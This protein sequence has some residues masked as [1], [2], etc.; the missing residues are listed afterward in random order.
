M[1]LYQDPTAPGRIRPNLMAELLGQP[2]WEQHHQLE[3]QASI[4]LAWL[5]DRSPVIA[6][7]LIDLWLEDPDLPAGSAIGARDQVSFPSKRRPDISIDVGDRALQLLIEVKVG[8]QLAD[9]SGVPQDQAY[10]DEWQEMTVGE[11]EVRAVGT[12]T[13]DPEAYDLPNKVSLPDFRARDVSWSE[14]KS[15]L[16][17][18]VNGDEVDSALAVVVRSFCD[19]IDLHID[20]ATV[21]EESLP[22][23]LDT[24]RPLVQD[25]ASD[26]GARLGTAPSIA[27]GAQ[28]AGAKLAY[29]ALDGKPVV[30]RIVAGVAG[31]VMTPVGAG[32]TLLVGVGRDHSVLLKGDDRSCGLEAG[33]EVIKTL[34]FT[35]TGLRMA[36]EEAER[37][38]PSVVA[39]LMP[40]L[41]TAG[42]LPP[43]SSER[44]ANEVAAAEGWEYK[45]HINL[46][47]DWRP[48]PMME[49]DDD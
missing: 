17:D 23:F 31:G 4:V 6:R 11:A 16:L 14:L 7:R 21:D 45:G 41:I 25:I 42:L 36:F 35:F 22:A 38:P 12:L 33:L 13:R 47:A 44:A 9:H 49:P 46:P 30:I 28:F 15:A 3:N 5:I 18:V 43:G 39:K 26:I 8:A 34:Q 27:H 32:P 48:T 1:T 19:A 2:A 10:R 24:A 37:D 40:I 29:E 20:V